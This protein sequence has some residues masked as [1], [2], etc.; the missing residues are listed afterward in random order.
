MF[1][2]NLRGLRCFAKRIE[3]GEFGFDQLWVF[4]RGSTWV[5]W[6]GGTNMVFFEEFDVN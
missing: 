1:W 6:G 4:G 2:R 3:G 5:C